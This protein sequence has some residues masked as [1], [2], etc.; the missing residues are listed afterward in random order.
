MHAYTKTSIVTRGR[1]GLR[2]GGSPVISAY[3]SILNLAGVARPSTVLA[4]N[5]ITSSVWITRYVD[6]RARQWYDQAVGNRD[7]LVCDMP[8]R[9][10][11]P[12]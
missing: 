5:P 3:P 9:G 7:P 11:W 6:R 10:L 2:P 12:R 1:L 4:R 8:S